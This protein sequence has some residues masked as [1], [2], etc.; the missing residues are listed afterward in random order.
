MKYVKYVPGFWTPYETWKPGV[1]V[2]SSP[3][4]RWP[5]D[6]GPRT[7][8]SVY[9]N[10]NVSPKRDIIVTE[11][12]NGINKQISVLPCPLFKGEIENVYSPFLKVDKSYRVFINNIGK[13]IFSDVAIHRSALAPRM[14]GGGYMTFKAHQRPVV[15]DRSFKLD[16]VFSAALSSYSVQVQNSAKYWTVVRHR[17]LC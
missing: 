8:C 12:R 9:R 6:L 4:T 11:T 17:C 16:C 5:S 7:T 1:H 15:C 10:F 13:N 2:F 3:G 14:I